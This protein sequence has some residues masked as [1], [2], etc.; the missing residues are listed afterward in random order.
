MVR[1]T[2]N[3]NTAA[4]SEQ[5]S[6]DNQNNNDDDDTTYSKHVLIRGYHIS[7][8]NL[9]NDYRTRRTRTVTNEKRDGVFGESV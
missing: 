6:E 9:G 8:R 4:K 1:L 3:E 2:G 5:D 7:R